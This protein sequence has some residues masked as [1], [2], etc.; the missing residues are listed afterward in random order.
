M[1]VEATALTG[2]YLIE[3]QAFADSRGVFM[4]TWH[5]ERYRQM[6]IPGPFVQDNY[7]Y[8]R[9]GVLRGL[10][11]QLKHPQG[12]LIGVLQGEVFDVVVDI[13]QNSPTFGRWVGERLSGD[14]HRQFYIPPG[15]AHGFCVLS[16]TAHVLYKCTDYYTPGDEYGLRWDD[17]YLSIPWPLTDPIVSEKDRLLPTLATLPSQ[18]LPRFEVQP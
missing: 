11:Y 4:E 12:K 6:H 10:H 9:R 7:S 16:E 1:R 2:V 17:A 13:R 14:N 3:P 15:F 5:A 18:H 8:S